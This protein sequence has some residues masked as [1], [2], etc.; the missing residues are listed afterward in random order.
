MDDLLLTVLTTLNE[1]LSA[2]IVVVAVSMLLYN[3]TRNVNNRVA[4][5]SAAVLA[6]VT[7][8]Y[9]A[10]VFTSLRPSPLTALNVQRLQ[11]LGIAFIPAAI[12]HL[13]DALLATTG[14]PSRGRRRRAV[15]LLYIVATVFLLLAVFT[16]VIVYPVPIEDG[17]FGLRAAPGFLIYLIYFT[18]ATVIGFINV[19]RARRRCQTRSTKRRMAY[20][21]AAL[22]TPLL[23][24][25]P[26]SAFFAANGENS[27]LALALVNVANLFVI[28]MLSFLAYPLS[29]FGSSIPD[30]AVKADL[31][32]FML[33]GPVTGLLILATIIF[34]SRATAIFSLPGD[35]FMPFAV[36]AVVL[37]WMWMS[38]LALPRLDRWLIYNE[39]DDS[40]LAKIQSL[41]RSLLTHDDLIQLL[42]AVLQA[43][44][45][46]LHVDD[47]FIVAIH[48]GDQEI[49][50]QMGGSSIQIE[51]IRP[52]IESLRRQFAD[53]TLAPHRWNGYW[54]FGLYSK[55]KTK[56]DGTP[57]LIGLMSVEAREDTD[58]RERD[59]D[60]LL[61]KLISQAARSLDDLLLQGEIFAVL[62]GL[63]PQFATTRQRTV[64]VEYKPGYT[65]TV[66]STSLALPFDRSQIIEQVQAA[67]RHYY[68]GPGMSQSRLLELRIVRDAF[69]AND[70]NPV[71]ALRAVLDQAIENQ[72]PAGDP[73]LRSQEWLLYNILEM[74][75]LKKRKVREIAER[76]YM[77]EANLYRKQSL[78]IEA[79]SDAL[80]KMELDN[81][82]GP[83]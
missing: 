40:Q 49:V 56:A 71:K 19:N 15:R 52:E 72:R 36:V 18:I 81:L 21:Q 82:N 68:G 60:G 55:R 73:D 14:L 74:R 27:I 59:H 83:A 9:V 30:R 35:S 7:I 54:V 25:F 1:I 67:L 16:D 43:T 31:L 33:R 64:D 11:W 22:L 51:Q 3:L 12:F 17:Y 37:F 76:L 75:F 23:G 38:D 70:N 28:L 77:S 62:E 10:D 46:Y 41:S 32:R 79:V 47:A 39:E 65:A 6:C 5:T 20:L 34:T 42:E 2:A 78:A 57:P 24:I 48:N 61:A 26:F 63:L 50:H 66:T 58:P 13:S 69:T 44:C 53:G 45:D 8:S 4:R 29:F 80:I